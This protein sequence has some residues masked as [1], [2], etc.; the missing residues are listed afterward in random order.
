MVGGGA[1]SRP[2]TAVRAEAVNRPTGPTGALYTL[3]LKGVRSPSTVFDRARHFQRIG[4][5]AVT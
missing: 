3:S 4:R 2:V 1:L 5:E